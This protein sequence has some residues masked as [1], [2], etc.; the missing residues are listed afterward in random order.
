[1]CQELQFSSDEQLENGL[2]Y[3]AIIKATKKGMVEFVTAIWSECP[4]LVSAEEEFTGRNP[5]MYAVLYRQYEIFRLLYCFNLKDSIL[6]ATDD[7]GNNILHMAAMTEPSARRNT[8]PGAAFHM[9]RD[10]QW[11]KVTSLAL[12]YQNPYI[13]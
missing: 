9:Q 1:M 5:F 4:E 8:I 10:L 3:E 13:I 11:F 7:K 2:V 6:A 12:H